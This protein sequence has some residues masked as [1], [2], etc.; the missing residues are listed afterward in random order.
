[1]VGLEIFELGGLLVDGAN[2]FRGY[3]RQLV[4]G[5]PEQVEDAP[6][7]LLPHRHL[8]GLAGVGDVHLPD[9][10]IGRGQGDGSHAVTA[11]VLLNLAG[12]VERVRLDLEGVVDLGQVPLRELGIQRGADNLHDLS[13]NHFDSLIALVRRALPLPR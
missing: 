2:H 4:H 6:E 1:M 12:E 5:L 13:G 9:H 8:D 10:S 3:G 7:D 11:E